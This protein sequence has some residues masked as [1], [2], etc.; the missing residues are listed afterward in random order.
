MA[1]INDYDVVNDNNTA[2]WPEGMPP[3]QVNDSARINEGVLARWHKDTNGSLLST[4]TSTAYNVSTNQALTAYYDG[5]EITFK[6]H[7]TCGNN[8]TLQL[9]A[10]PVA[11]I[12]TPDGVNL[13]DGNISSGA[14]TNVIYDG[15]KWQL[16]NVT[17][18][19][20]IAFLSADNAFTGANTFSN[21]N[22]TLQF[23]DDGAGSGPYLNIFR[24][25][26]SPADD[27][28]LGEVLF[29]GKNSSAV[30]LN[31]ARLAA[32]ALDVT[33]GT[34]D[35]ELRWST[36]S[37]G[38]SADILIG[39]KGLIVPDSGTLPT[40]GDLGP[41]SI[42]ARGAVARNGIEYQAGW[43]RY[44]RA[45]TASGSS[46][47]ISG[48]D[49][50]AQEFI[51]DLNLVSTSSSSA[52][53]ELTIG[54]GTTP[55]TTGYNSTAT[56]AAGTTTSSTN[57]NTKAIIRR[58]SAG[59]PFHL[60]MQGYLIDPAT[61]RWHLHYIGGKASTSGTTFGHTTVELGA[62]NPLGIVQIAPDSGT[63]TA[64]DFGVMS[65]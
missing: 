56:S 53:I 14:K 34:E 7:V 33:S 41:G 16:M 36:F 38:L 51:V 46:S 15:S 19:S 57:T 25:S 26:A 42:N 62:G 54:T 11:D 1:E 48:I 32:K 23:D 58:V 20:D 12:I 24:N 2:R 13:V 60:T 29:R 9:G 17:A 43:N 65:R 52:S 3:S 4:G 30:T 50:N 5:L 47:S 64:G 8:P 21:Q 31:Y 59:Q 63:F 39:R 28:L 6:A 44:T 37:G 35:G 61:N 49:T 45:S 40:D 18:I 55:Q 10:L 27:D 22:T